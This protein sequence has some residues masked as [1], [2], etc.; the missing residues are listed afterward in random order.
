MQKNGKFQKFGNIWKK[1]SN[2]LLYF[3]L[4]IQETLIILLKRLKN[5]RFSFPFN[6]KHPFGPIEQERV[7][8]EKRREES[9]DNIHEYLDYSPAGITASNSTGQKYSWWP[10]TFR[11]FIFRGNLSTYAKWHENSWKIEI[12]SRVTY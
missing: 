6:S 4:Q 7:R 9:S 12:S 5:R 2:F 8:R 11:Y 10:T 1:I 3:I